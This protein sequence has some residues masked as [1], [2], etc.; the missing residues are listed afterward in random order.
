VKSFWYLSFCDED[1]PV[2]TQFVGGAVVEAED[3]EDAVRVAWREGCNPG[4]GM[5]AIQIPEDSLPMPD[6][7][8][9]RLMT[10][11]ELEG[12]DKI[13]GG[14]GL[15]TVSLEEVIDDDDTD[16][17]SVGCVACDAENLRKK[18]N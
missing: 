16:V 14:T 10:E 15:A 11:A 3:V 2:G 5:L 7:Y 4:V 1:R 8:L 13:L 6:G 18:L 17:D 12:L 9:N